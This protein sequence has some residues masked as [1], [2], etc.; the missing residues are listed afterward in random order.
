MCFL[1]PV[2]RA[3]LMA[4]ILAPTLLLS[5]QAFGADLSPDYVGANWAASSNYAIS[6][7]PAPGLECE[8]DT[9][10]GGKL[11]AGYTLGSSVVFG[12]VRNISAIELSVF[13]VDG[14]KGYLPRWD[15]ALM[16]GRYKMDGLA[17][18]HASVLTVSDA[19]GLETRL[20][21]SY[22]RGSVAYVSPWR[23]NDYGANGSDHR[24]R[25]GLTAGVGLSY[26][27]TGNW[28]LHGDYDYVP[29]KYA[30]GTGNSHVNMWSLGTSYHF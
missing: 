12:D 22:T 4:A 24:Y 19:L 7:F 6:C 10:R 26:A 13:A 9:S 25:I 17:L 8:R 30:L 21:V 28:S 23:L 3:V 1:L 27:L 15:G 5:D 20:G 18:S 29:V 11:Y 2:S 14:A 16:Q